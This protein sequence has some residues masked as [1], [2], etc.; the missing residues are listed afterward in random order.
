MV[1]SLTAAQPSPT[2]GEHWASV[3]ARY[4]G[5]QAADYWRYQQPIGQ[6]VGRR[7]AW[8]FDSHVTTSDR[9]VELGCGGGYL[10]ERLVGQTKV[11]VEV[12]PLA[13]AAAVE[14]GLDVRRS[15][16][17]IDDAWADVVIS[18][19]VLEHV[20]EPFNV[21]TQ[22][23][24]I[25]R[26]GGKLVLCLPI[27]DWRLHRQATGPDINGHLWT[28]TPQLIHNVLHEVGFVDV[29][30]HVVPYSWPRGARLLVRW[31]W[32]YR[33]AA[34][35]AGRWRRCRELHVVAFKQ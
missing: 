14:R 13:R 5:R 8:K 35:A 4:S 7:D 26:S 31:P 11:G 29:V 30:A 9:V 2:T 18:H 3:G 28:W 1:E 24:S 10:L 20:L 15:L 21:L 32:L 17:E 22:L 12:N 6:T 16:V 23:R 34:A 33:A 27:D 25:L 19:H